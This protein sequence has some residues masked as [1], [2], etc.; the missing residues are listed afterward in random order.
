MSVFAETVRGTCARAAQW[1]GVFAGS[2][3]MAAR[4]CKQ[5]GEW[6]EFI[7]AENNA[8]RFGHNLFPLPEAKK[9]EGGQGFEGKWPSP[10]RSS[11]ASTSSTSAVNSS[12]T[13]YSK[14]APSTGRRSIRGS[15]Q[16]RALFAS[17]FWRSDL[18]FDLLQRRITPS[19]FIVV[20]TY[21]FYLQVA[22]NLY[23]DL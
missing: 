6:Q 9:L 10:T 4:W 1:L 16:A 18:D 11:S 2:A 17:F 21:L 5:A 19:N 12:P 15:G 22:R 3:F 8:D 20:R 13:K 14:S 23:V 7:C